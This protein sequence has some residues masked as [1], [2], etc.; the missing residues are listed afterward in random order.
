MIQ[1]LLPPLAV[2]ASCVSAMVYNAPRATSQSEHGDLPTFPPDPTPAAV[3]LPELFKRQ[4]L[5]TA[6][7]APDNT[8]GYISGLAGIYSQIAI[9]NS[10][11]KY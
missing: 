8:C 10:A 6:L 7:I 4:S 5:Y 9:L 2:F 3:A 11:N 1:S